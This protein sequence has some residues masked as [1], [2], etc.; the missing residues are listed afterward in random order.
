VL[1]IVRVILALIPIL[2][3]LLNLV[4]TLAL[5]AVLVVLI[6]GA[7]KGKAYRIPVVGNLLNVF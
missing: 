4:I 1:S 6:I 7:A 2:G 3:V 5:V